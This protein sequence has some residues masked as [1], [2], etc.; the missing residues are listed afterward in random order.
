MREFEIKK[1][2]AGQ[3][4]DKFLQKAVPSL[5]QALLYKYLRLKRIKRNGKR[6]D[7]AARLAEG[8]RIQ[9]YI[10][11]EFFSPGGE[12]AFL[13]APARID[14]VYE[15]AN[16]LLVYKRPGLVVHEDDR[17][18][19]D[20]L[21]ARIR[22]YL[23]EKGEYDPADELSFAPALCNRIDRNT[24]GLVLAAKTA[25]ALRILNEKI[26]LREVKKFYLCLAHGVFKQKAGV[27]EG[28]LE[29]DSAE[30]RVYVHESRRPGDLS[31]SLRYRVLGERNALSL[32]EVELLTGRTHQIRAQLAYAGHPLLGDG[33]Y[34]RNALD[35]PYG[36]THQALCAYKVAFDFASDAGALSYLK[37]KTVELPE[38]GFARAFREG[39]LGR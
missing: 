34:G 6:A 31:A 29:K 13:H 32:V 14:A 20:T 12:N 7:I 37:G 16:V 35:A 1:N 24:E 4:L 5:P 26:R 8:D 21:I 9:L 11:D 28:F 2:D 25:E 38:V 39:T 17:G 15:D 22:H 30:K 18:S 3:R 23:Y 10:G 19:A 27:L 36:F 33:K